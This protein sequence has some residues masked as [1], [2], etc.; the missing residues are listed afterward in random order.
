MITVTKFPFPLQTT[1]SYLT[2]FQKLSKSD[3]IFWLITLSMI[4]LSGAHSTRHTKIS[5]WLLPR[6]CCR[7]GRAWWRTGSWWGGTSWRCPSGSWRRRRCRWSDPSASR[8][9]PPGREDGRDRDERT[10]WKRSDFLEIKS[11]LKGQIS[12][13]R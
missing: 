6:A 4:T 1:A 3:N 12:F 10:W 11:V 8:S 13:K 5:H 9:S 7:R 2:V